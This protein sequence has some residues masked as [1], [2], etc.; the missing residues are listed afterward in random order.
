MGGLMGVISGLR[1]AKR[2]MSHWFAAEPWRRQNAHLMRSVSDPRE[3][4]GEPVDYKAHLLAA[5][6]WLERC[7]DASRDGGLPGRYRLR[8]GWTPSYP[9]TTGYAVPTFLRL[10]RE[11]PR[12]RLVSRAKS[13]IEFLLGRQ[14]IEGGFPGGEVGSDSDISVFNT[15][16]ILAGLDAWDAEYPSPEVRDVAAGA[17]DW[18]IRVQHDDG[19]WRDYTYG[20]LACAYYA[21]ASC[22]LAAFGARVD[23][24]R[25]TEAAQRQIEWVISRQ[26]P[27]SGWIEGAGF[28]RDHPARITE[29]HTLGYTLWGLLVA[30]EALEHNDAR[31]AAVLAARRLAERVVSERWLAG[32]Y[33]HLWRP[34]STYSCLTG[35]VQ[36]AQVW[37]RLAFSDD[38]VDGL[39]AG[40]AD[41]ALRSVLAAQ[42]LTNRDPGIRGGLPGSTPIGGDYL[43]N[44][45]PNWSAKFLVDTLLDLAASTE[46]R[47]DERVDDWI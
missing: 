8:G 17:A 23:E 9:E 45:I 10:A 44:T 39:F 40:A 16:Q 33:D 42:P 5:V 7:H 26:D 34:V 22:W 11:L 29:T 41:V 21:H 37:L 28:P 32:R 47:E 31:A 20:G 3:L 24:P 13:C 2:R 35:S 38:E 19:A 27:A 12:E 14:R 30:A 18:L 1:R 4:I 43:P 25:Y 6:D 36:L 15:G 46:T